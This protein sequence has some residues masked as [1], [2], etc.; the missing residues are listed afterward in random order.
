[1]H[2]KQSLLAQLKALGIDPNGTTLFHGSYKSLGDVAGGGQTVVDTLVEYMRPGLMVFP[3][4]TWAVVNAEQ[5]YYSVQQTPSNIGIIPNLA[6]QTTGGVRSGHPTHSVVAFGKEA[7]AFI[8]DDHKTTTPCAR[9]SS[10]GK[11]LDRNATILLVGVGLNR[12]TFIHGVEEWLDI[13][14]R[15]EETN[16]ILYS[17]L[18]DGRL[19]VVVQHRHA[20][21]VG[22]NFPRVEARLREIGVL[23]EGE[24]GDAKV[25][26]HQARP[27]YEA[28]KV[29]LT[30]KP[31]LFGER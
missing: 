17:R 4:H 25:L 29:L 12:D 20:G 31:D 3:T 16:Q 1:M 6:R 21:H 8:K 5:P 23:K 2:T 28:L 10:W 27:L 22:E 13:P 26:Y 19:E 14:N 11:L 7:K 18:A 24:F 30:E 15:L 9:N